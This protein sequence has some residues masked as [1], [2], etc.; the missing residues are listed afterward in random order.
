M[1]ES[2][3]EMTMVSFHHVLMQKN[4]NLKTDEIILVLIMHYG[5]KKMTVFKENK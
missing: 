2:Q 5:K 1:T 3:K 4:D